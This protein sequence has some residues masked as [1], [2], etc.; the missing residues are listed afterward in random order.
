MDSKEN[1][2]ELLHKNLNSILLNFV[3]IVVKEQLI[4]TGES[5]TVGYGPDW[6]DESELHYKVGEKFGIRVYF[7][8]K[9][10]SDQPLQILFVLTDSLGDVFKQF[11]VAPILNVTL[12]NNELDCLTFSAEEDI[13]LIERCS[14]LF[15][16]TRN[17]ENFQEFCNAV[18]K[19]LLLTSIKHS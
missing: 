18:S 17:E 7:V 8:D 15:V 19:H 14:P 4:V 11:G 13:Q 9:Q 3:R 6:R 1:E 16:R 10:R 12:E 5:Y 2:R